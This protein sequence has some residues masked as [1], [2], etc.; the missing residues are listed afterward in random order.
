MTSLTDRDIEAILGR[1]VC[2]LLTAADRRAFAGRRVLITGAG[3][4]IGSEL[5]R[6]V[7]ACAPARLTLIDHAEL[8]LFQIEQELARVAPA[9]PLDVV[10]ADVA[11]TNLEPV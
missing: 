7:A 5:A 4:S 9:V 10:L 3:G 8:N 11:H 2:R 1:P 6:Q